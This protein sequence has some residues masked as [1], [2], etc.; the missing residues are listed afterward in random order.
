MEQIKKNKHF[1]IIGVL[2]LIY[3]FLH[4]FRLGDLPYAINIDEAGLWYN[5]K[6]LLEYGYAQEGKSFPLL[7]TNYYSEQSAMYTYLALIFIKLFG[8]SLFVLRLP[9]VLNA[10]VIFI[11]GCKIINRLYS[12]KKVEVLYCLFITIFPYFVINGR[13]A[14]DCNLMLGFSIIFL[15]YLITAIASGNWKHYLIA[16]MISGLTL[17]TYA[18]SYITIPIFVA[19][20]GGYLISNKKITIKNAIVFVAPI[21][22]LGAPLLLIQIINIF[23]LPEMKLLW[24]TLPNLE[25]PRHADVALTNIIGHLI[26]YGKYIFMGEEI[27]LL[28]SQIF[29]SN[30]YIISIPFLIIGFISVLK[31]KGYSDKKIILFWLIATFCTLML[32]KTG[33]RGYQTNALMFGCVALII[34]GIMVSMAKLKNKNVVILVLLVLYLV[35][36]GFFCYHYFSGEYNDNVYKYEN[37]NTDFANVYEEL[38]DEP[39]VYCAVKSAYYKLALNKDPQQ[40]PFI[41]DR[42]YNES[43]EC[44]GIQEQIYSDAGFVFDHT[45]AFLKKLQPN[46]IYVIPLKEVNMMEKMQNHLGWSMEIVNQYAIFKPITVA[47]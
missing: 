25:S 21:I 22:F 34:E 4:L 45:G 6:S 18:I 23:E 30:F 19:I 12:D 44:I 5:V 14:L 43:G 31:E 32:I 29:C 42:A 9:A 40:H 41:Y 28:T 17:Y 8:S 39:M 36:F 2:F 46:A 13:I 38:K 27:S 1:I 35:S 11:F 37:S 26:V 47:K 24:F 7:F 16:G 3:I 15:Y 33:L 20:T 10:A